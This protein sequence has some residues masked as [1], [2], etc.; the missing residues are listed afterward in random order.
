MKE[1]YS[2]P[3]QNPSFRSRFVMDGNPSLY[4]LIPDDCDAITIEGRGQAP[5]SMKLFDI[6]GT[7]LARNDSNQA[8][9]TLEYR[10][11]RAERG[12]VYRLLPMANSIH[13][14]SGPGYFSFHPERLFVPTTQF[15]REPTQ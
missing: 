6:A 9:R 8:T 5:V 2:F 11:L 1:V 12:K 10:P 13:V 14:K 7:I 4:F 15:R 3:F